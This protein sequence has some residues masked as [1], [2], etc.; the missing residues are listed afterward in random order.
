MT[1]PIGGASGPAQ[2]A[3]PPHSSAVSGMSS[4]DFMKLLVA[5]LRYQ[6]PTKPTDA[7]AFMSQTAQLTQV[8]TLTSIAAAQ[9]KMLA[10][11]LST[12]ASGLVGHTV[13]YLDAD[14]VKQS[15]T[16][17]SATFGSSP[18]LRIGDLNVALSAVVGE[19]QPE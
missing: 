14:G 5:Q 9:G 6:D 15:G 10:S 12:Q 16:V 13:D 7:T 19:H 1:S 11:A 18:T 17:T 3:T 2:A 4:D 8:D